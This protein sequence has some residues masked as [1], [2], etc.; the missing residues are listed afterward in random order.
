[1]P[2]IHISALKPNI[3]ASASEYSR[4]IERLVRLQTS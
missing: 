1:M 4:N 3:Y 2:F